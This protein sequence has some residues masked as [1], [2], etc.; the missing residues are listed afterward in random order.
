MASF[1]VRISRRSLVS[2]VEHLKSLYS[3]WQKAKSESLCLTSKPCHTSPVMS[4]SSVSVTRFSTL[5]VTYFD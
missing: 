5:Q 1:G 3:G 2:S 4:A